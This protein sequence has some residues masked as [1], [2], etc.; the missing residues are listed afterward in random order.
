MLMGHQQRNRVLL[1]VQMCLSLLQTACFVK[2]RLRFKILSRLMQDL[3]A[4][5]CILSDLQLKVLYRSKQPLKCNSE[6]QQIVCEHELGDHAE[7]AVCT[8]VSFG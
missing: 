3:T 6:V 1:S 2:I 4:A 7:C 8:V 5:S